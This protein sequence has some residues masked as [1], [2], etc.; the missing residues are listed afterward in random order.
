MPVR[1]LLSAVVLF[2]LL[3]IATVWSGVFSGNAHAGLQTLLIVL[4]PETDTNDVGTDHTLTATVTFD[5]DPQPDLTVDFEVLS[6]GP[7]EGEIGQDITGVNGEATFTYTG[8]GGVGQDTIQACVTQIPNIVGQPQ[9][10]ATATKDWVQP[11]PTPT[12]TP[13]P[14]ATPTQTA[15][16]AQLP[17]TGTQPPAGSGFPWS[18]VAIV[19]LSALAVGAAGVVMRRR[20]H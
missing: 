1:Y 3:A 11:T 13:S 9:D 16:A 8:D 12:P 19:A 20:A 18:S 5:G 6:G 2:G 7:N 10:C 4:D 17:E 15:P 14:T